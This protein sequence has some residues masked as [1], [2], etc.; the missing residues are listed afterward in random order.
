MK[1]T[2]WLFSTPQLLPKKL[3]KRESK[4]KTKEVKN[5]PGCN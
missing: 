2:G 1:V 3:A 4:P 5:F